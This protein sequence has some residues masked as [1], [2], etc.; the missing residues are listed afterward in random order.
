MLYKIILA[1]KYVPN[2]L[3]QMLSDDC[4][5]STILVFLEDEKIFLF[6]A[7]TKCQFK[8]GFARTQ[9]QAVSC[10]AR[11]AIMALRPARVGGILQVGRL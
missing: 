6:D 1:V 8:E 3:S 2:F 4:L 10:V 9:L 5:H 11:A 7:F